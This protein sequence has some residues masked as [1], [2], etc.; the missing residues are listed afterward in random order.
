MTRAQRAQGY[1]EFLAEEGYRPRL[2]ADGDVVFKV[3]GGAYYILLDE[4]E[5]FFRL[6]YPNFWPLETE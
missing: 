4:D 1:L 2:D 5:E 6:I 3:E